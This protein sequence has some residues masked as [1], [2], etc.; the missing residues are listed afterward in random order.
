MKIQFGIIGSAL[1]LSLSLQTT[2]ADEVPDIRP[3]LWQMTNFKEDGT[4]LQTSTRCVDAASE[5]RARALAETPESK[6]ACP[7]NRTEKKGDGFEV[8]SECNIMGS[9]Y[10]SVSLTSGD[11]NSAYTTINTTTSESPSGKP[12]KR[13]FKS[14]SKWLGEC[15]P[16]MKPGDISVDGRPPVNGVDQAL[17]AK[18]LHDQLMKSDPNFAKLVNKMNAS[19]QPLAGTTAQGTSGNAK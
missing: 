11:F 14:E 10:I 12:S 16:N 6:K 15:P 5:A 4:K 19:K 3:G 7:V 9:K 13:V 2:F 18:K 17:K 1:L 8:Y